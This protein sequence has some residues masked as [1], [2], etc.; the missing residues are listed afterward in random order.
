MTDLD[1]LIEA[2]EAGRDDSE[3]WRSAMGGNGYLAYKAM[4]SFHGSIDAA[5]ELHAALL[6]GAC[7]RLEA[8]RKPTAWVS[9]RLASTWGDAVSA[10]TIARA[11]LLAI[12][13]A[14]RSQVQ[15]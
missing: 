13:Y 2:V 7:V 5:K 3:K 11:W 10:E 9:D 4:E 6:P 1:K 12:L 8:R 14:Y 15:K